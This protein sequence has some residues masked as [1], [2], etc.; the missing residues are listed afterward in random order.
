MSV[1]LVRVDQRLIHGQVVEGWLRHLKADAIVVADDAVAGDP[2]CTLAMTA[3][4]PSKVSL[5]VV[6][7]GEAA[8]AAKRGELAKKRVLVLV[9]SVD[10]LDRVWHSGLTAPSVNVGNVPLVPGRMRVTPSVALSPG[11]L[12]TLDEIARSG[13]AVEVKAVPREK[14]LSLKSAHAAVERQERDRGA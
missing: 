14:G 8:Q 7:V 9:S 11:E 12:S 10:G 5:D 6:A 4:C 3:A 2:L 13:V 1:V